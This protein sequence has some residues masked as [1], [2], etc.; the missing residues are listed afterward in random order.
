[1]DE[2][3]GLIARAEGLLARLEGLLPEAPQAP[4]WTAAIAFRWRSRNGRGW[5]QPVAHPHRMRLADLCRIDEQKKTVERNTRQFV[6]GRSANNVL[7]TGARGTGKSS[8][9]KAVL[10]QYARRGLRLIEID[11]QHLGDLPDIVDLIHD[12]PER[13]DAEATTANASPARAEPR[14]GT[15]VLGCRVREGGIASCHRSRQRLRR[16]RPRFD[17]DRRRPAVK[18]LIR[19]LDW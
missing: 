16:L 2:V 7:L 10:N 17:T 1:M 3:K 11:K 12:R 14:N 9:V 19:W 13:F 15:C 6:E 5:L 4:Q 8:L 18:E